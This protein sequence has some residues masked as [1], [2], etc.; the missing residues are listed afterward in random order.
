MGQPPLVTWAIR[1]QRERCEACFSYDRGGDR[2]HDLRIKRHLRNRP[3][4]TDLGYERG[5]HML[6]WYTR[7]RIIC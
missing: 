7:S 5:N 4:C 1:V 2:T 6:G 3:I